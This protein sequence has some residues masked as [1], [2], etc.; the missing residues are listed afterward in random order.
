MTY[1]PNRFWGAERQRTLLGVMRDRQADTADG[2]G[3]LTGAEHELIGMLGEVAARFREITGPGL[4][5]EGDLA[6]IVFHVHALQ[7]AVLAQA[8]G[9]AYPE[10]YR[11]LGMTLPE[12]S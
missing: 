4:P 9:R 12:P 1:D 11:T 10:N 5:R 3:L 6:E 7:R 2:T 8:A